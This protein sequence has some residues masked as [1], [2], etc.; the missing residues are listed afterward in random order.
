MLL[1]P[2]HL[3]HESILAS[4]TSARP[5]FTGTVLDLGCGDQPYSAIIRK[6]VAAYIGTDISLA[7]TPPPDVCSDS[8]ELPFKNNS[9]DTVVSTQVIEHV[10]NPFAMMYEIA[11]VLK[12][13]GHVVLTAPQLWPLHEEPY[14]FFRYTKYALELLANQHGLDVVYIKERGGAIAALG[15][16]ISILLYD[17]FAKGAFQRALTKCICVPLLYGCGML[18][19][20]WFNPKLTLG[21]VMVARKP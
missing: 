12:P 9:F 2:S 19:R 6:G 13:R 20:L 5:Y 18:D 3:E 1:N 21:Y 15:Q 14:D 17:R 8:L 7:H 16:M 4:L 11:R 10:R